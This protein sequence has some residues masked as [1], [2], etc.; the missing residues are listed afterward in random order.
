MSASETGSN[1]V[2][3]RGESFIYFN[4]LNRLTGRVLGL[5][6]DL[7]TAFRL[8][9]TGRNFLQMLIGASIIA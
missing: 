9:N 8:D 1:E 5:K 4:V 6:G 7:S 2:C 3:S